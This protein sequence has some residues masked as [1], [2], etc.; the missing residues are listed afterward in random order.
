V[1]DIGVRVGRSWCGDHRARH[2]GHGSAYPGGIVA[3]LGGASCG[4]R[5]APVHACGRRFPADRSQPPARA[6]RRGRGGAPV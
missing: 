5:V 4:A 1:I 3:R 6:A 2:V